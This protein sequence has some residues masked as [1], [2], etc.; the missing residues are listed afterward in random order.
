MDVSMKI[1][2]LTILPLQT[3]MD[4]GCVYTT[5]RHQRCPKIEDR[6][7]FF[8]FLYYII[9][10]PVHELHLVTRPFTLLY[11]PVA[12]RVANR[13]TQLSGLNSNEK[14]FAPKP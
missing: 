10:T 9:C 1:V 14:C 4:I 7:R 2:A 11:C 3:R 8:D 6:A 13:N 5:A 12:N